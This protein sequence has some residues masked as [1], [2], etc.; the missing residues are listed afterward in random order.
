MK[1]DIEQRKLVI[2]HI[3]IDTNDYDAGECPFLIAELINSIRYDQA[4]F[5]KEVSD[6]VTDCEEIQKCIFVK[7]ES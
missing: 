3:T 1:I 7:G 4:E 2:S 5:F 6:Y